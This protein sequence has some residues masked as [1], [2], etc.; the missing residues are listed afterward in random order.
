MR[1]GQLPP[2]SPG[3]VRV[4]VDRGSFCDDF[5][6]H[7]VRYWSLGGT[8]VLNDPFFT[9]VFD[10]LSEILLYDSLS[11]SHPRTILLPRVNHSEDLTEMVGGPDWDAIAAG[12]GIPCILKPVDGY[13]WQDVFR[14]EDISTLR[15][16]YESL[17]DSRTLMV[18]E[19]IRH[20]G[21][22]RAFCIDRREVM[23]VKWKPL[24]FDHGEYS[25]PEPHELDA[26]G[27]FVTRKT[28]ELNA[29]L[30]LD[31]NAV[32]WCITKEGVPVVIDSFNDVPDVRREKLPPSCYDWVVDRFSAC[33]RQKLSS[34]GRN[35]LAPWRPSG[36]E[37]GTP[38][39]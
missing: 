15:S 11:I 5:L 14:V 26:F 25:L 31:F 21:Y 28:I 29:G 20:E 9:L 24:P 39:G 17:K 12:V 4:I 16:L 19:L 8:Y 27:D 3:P 2:P 35:S 6:R 10:K 13:A 36:S 18:Q 38:A 32:E 37:A 23:I 30:C 7:V 34:A 1:V 33:V 22:Y